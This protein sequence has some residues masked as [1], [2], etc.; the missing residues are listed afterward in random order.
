VKAA[1]YQTSPPE[2]SSPG[3]GFAESRPPPQH[4]ATAISTLESPTS[5]LDDCRGAGFALAGICAAS[6]S[7]HADEVRRWIA[8]GRHGSMAWLESRLDER[9][10]PAVYLPGARTIICVADRYHDGSRDTV[11]TDGPLRGRIARYARGRDYHKTMKKRLVRLAKSWSERHP[12][13]DFRP[14]VDTAPVLE[15]EHAMRAGLGLVGKHSLLIEPGVGSW[16]LLGAVVTTL[17]IEPTPPRFR[18]ADPCGECTRCID[19]CPTQAITPFS[20]DASRCLAYTTIEHRGDIDPT[21]A[22]ATGDWLFGCD[23][24]QEVCPHGRRARRRPSPNTHPDLAARHDGFDLLEVLGWTESAAFERL[25]GTAARRATLVMWKR[26]A[27]VCATNLLRERP[28]A[29]DAD[30]VRARIAEIAAD[31]SEDDLVRSTAVWS[32]AA[33]A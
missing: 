18:R 14:C 28:D 20:V 5:F 8:D 10:D 1:R 12:D 25:E 3:S 7:D 6:P 19:A 31:D 24:C 13:A 23:I 2:G 33:M 21:L 15:R 4:P 27:I 17:A 30:A 9:L 32:L 29:S 16:M 26:N 22:A 11:A